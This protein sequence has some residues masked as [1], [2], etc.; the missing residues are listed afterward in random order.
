MLYPPSHSS[1]TFPS[2]I[3]LILYAHFSSLLNIEWWN[4]CPLIQSPSFEITVFSMAFPSQYPNLLS[5][6]VISLT[7]SKIPT[8]LL[9]T[10]DLSII[11]FPKYISPP[12]SAYIG[13]LFSYKSNIDFLIDS[14]FSNFS[15]KISGNPPP[16]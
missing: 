8:I 15:A 14:F 7:P 16:M 4:S 13:V 2:L 10:P 9:S 1:T 11:D 12:H 6:G 3:F 5:L